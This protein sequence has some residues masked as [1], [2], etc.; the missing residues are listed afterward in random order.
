MSSQARQ[1]QTCV[2]KP[3]CQLCMQTDRLKLRLQH[4]NSKTEA[5]AARHR[6]GGPLHQGKQQLGEHFQQ[7]TGLRKLTDPETGRL[8]AGVFSHIC[9]C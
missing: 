2:A 9:C 7:H 1:A 8:S 3:H 6:M 5:A 4:R